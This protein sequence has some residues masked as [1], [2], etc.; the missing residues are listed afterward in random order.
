[1]GTGAGESINP[2]F[3]TSLLATALGLSLGAATFVTP[4]EAA[5]RL[6]GGGTE[7]FVTYGPSRGDT[8][9][10]GTHATLQ[11]GGR[12]TGYTARSGGQARE[13]RIGQSIGGGRDQAVVYGDG[14]P[15]GWAATEADIDERG[16]RG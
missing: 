6:S 7:A 16:H 11:G 8:I 12:D 4:A 1:M 15:H 3:R 13:G 10:G 2:M 5:P 9:V 14:M